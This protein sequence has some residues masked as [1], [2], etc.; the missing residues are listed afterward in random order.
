[1]EKR[2]KE[3]RLRKQQQ[4]PDIESTLATLKLL[5]ARNATATDDAPLRVQYELC[6]TLYAKASIKKTDRVFLWLGV[7]YRERVIR[8]VV[9]FNIQFYRILG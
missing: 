8:G 4:L 5:Q 2:Y 1:L 3:D 6:D 9:F 7:C